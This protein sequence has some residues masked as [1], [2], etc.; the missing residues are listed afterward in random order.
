MIRRTAASLAGRHPWDHRAWRTLRRRSAARTADK[1]RTLGAVEDTWV[2]RDLPVL[3]AT[4]ELLQEKDLPE[5][6]D[7]AKRAGIDVAKVGQGLRDMDG[8]YVDLNMSGLSP[9]RWCVMGV[10]P[11]ARRAVG[12]WPTPEGL[13]DR[14]AEAF[15]KAADREADPKRKG[16]LR[17]IAGFL[18]DTGKELAA[19]VIAKVISRQTGIG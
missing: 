9:E 12:Q 6:G 14:L 15:S 18:G 11:E 13:T 8:L 17:E 2:S 19:E 5:V 3:D 7:I 4:V 1:L 10:Y 16:R